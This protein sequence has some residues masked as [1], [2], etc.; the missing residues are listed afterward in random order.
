M[1]TGQSI[2]CGPH[3][4]GPQLEVLGC[5]ALTGVKWEFEP[6]LDVLRTLRCPGMHV[7]LTG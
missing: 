5:V 1:A 4:D 6:Q 2:W 3:R 7:A